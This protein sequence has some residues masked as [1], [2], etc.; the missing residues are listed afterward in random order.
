MVNEGLLV[1]NLLMLSRLGL[2]KRTVL[3]LNRFNLF[4]LYSGLSITSSVESGVSLK[5]LVGTFKIDGSGWGLGHDINKDLRH[6]QV[7]EET[8]DLKEALIKIV[9]IVATES[10]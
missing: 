5:Q 7:R 1:H 4:F 10:S 9:S 3:A 6:V 8:L 2:L